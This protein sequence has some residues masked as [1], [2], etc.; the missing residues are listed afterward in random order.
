[1]NEMVNELVATLAFAGVGLAL[2]GLGYWVLDLLIP[3]HL[4]RLVFI[5][6]K[7]DAAL[8]LGASILSLGG[9][10]ATAIW[11]AETDTWETVLATAGFGLLGVAIQAIA[12]IALDLLTPGR[13]GHMVADDSDDPAVWVIVATQLAVGFILMASLT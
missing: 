5:D 9:V 11:S 3:G 8:V 4:G 10:I 13:L 12:F 1:M 6:H 7:R 2:L